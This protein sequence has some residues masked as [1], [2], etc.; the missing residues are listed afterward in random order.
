MQRQV[1]SFAPSLPNFSVHGDGFLVTAGGAEQVAFFQRD[2]NILRI[3]WDQFARELQRLV[4][5]MFAP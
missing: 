1:F 5:S 2:Q 3:A 4:V